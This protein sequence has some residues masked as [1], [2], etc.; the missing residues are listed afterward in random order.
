MTMEIYEERIHRE[1]ID[2]GSYIYVPQYNCF[3]TDGKWE[4]W[5]GKFINDIWFDKVVFKTKQSAQ[6]WLLVKSE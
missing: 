6:D 2:D 5:C 1:K 4:H 3:R